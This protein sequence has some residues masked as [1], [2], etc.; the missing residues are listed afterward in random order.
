MFNR[1]LLDLREIMLIMNMLKVIMMVLIFGP[2]REKMFL[3]TKIL[4]SEK[5]VS[6]SKIRR[7]SP[8]DVLLCTENGCF[9]L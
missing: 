7:T 9:E 8:R 2:Q 6:E 3:Q 4:I 1:G 5:Q